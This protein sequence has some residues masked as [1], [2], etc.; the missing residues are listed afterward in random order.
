M[1]R[2]QVRKYFINNQTWVYIQEIIGWSDPEKRI[3]NKKG[4]NTS[5]EMLKSF[6]RQKARVIKSEYSFGAK[7]RDS[8][9]Y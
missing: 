3:K 4:R 9:L 5:S 8:K 2:S 7:R 1:Q 6:W